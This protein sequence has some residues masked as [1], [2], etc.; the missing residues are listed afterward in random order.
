MWTLNTY[1]P[2]YADE[3][4]L[5]THIFGTEMWQEIWCSFLW[6]VWFS[7]IWFWRNSCSGSNFL[8]FSYFRLFGEFEPQAFNFYGILDQW[9]IL[10]ASKTGVPF[11]GAWKIKIELA[12]RQLVQTSGR[13]FGKFS[14]K[15][16]HTLTISLPKISKNKRQTRKCFYQHPL[17]VYRSLENGNGI[18]G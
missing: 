15:L 3:I 2:V 5:L 1:V 8:E 12:F 10:K 11:Q 9:C 14:I 18:K 7:S 17:A 6:W 16:T 4:L 13:V